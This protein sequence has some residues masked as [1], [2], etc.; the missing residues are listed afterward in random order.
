MAK[1]LIVE[2]DQLMSR[3]YEKAFRFEKYEVELA[4]NGDDGLA[5]AKSGKPTLILLDIMMPG[6]N[7]FEVLEE[8]KARTDTKSI[9]VIV[10]TNLAGTGDAEKAMKMGAVKYIIKSEY[11]PTQVVSMVKEVLAGYTRQDVPTT[12][13]VPVKK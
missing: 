7:G 3:L 4:S 6:K 5:K 11:E 9:P 13:P 12:A 8:L 2:D 1:V 10:L